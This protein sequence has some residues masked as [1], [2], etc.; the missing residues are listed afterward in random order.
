MNNQRKNDLLIIK[1]AI[2]KECEKH[3]LPLATL[4]D[5]MDCFDEL[6][7]GRISYQTI[8]EDT[9]KWYKK[10][11]DFISARLHNDSGLFV[12]AFKY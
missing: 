4:H 8:M 2:E 3:K 1:N 10:N 12:I 5:I 7:M 9:A 11:F 6:L